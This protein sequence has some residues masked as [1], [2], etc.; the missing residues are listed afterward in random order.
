MYHKDLS[1]EKLPDASSTDHQI[2]LGSAQQSLKGPQNL[3]IEYEILNKALSLFFLYLYPTYMF[4]YRE[5][6]LEDYHENAH[7]GKYW[8]YPLLYAICAL[9]L[10]ASP[11]VKMREKGD[12]LY[13]YAEASILPQA[14]GSPNVT[15][16]QSLLCLAFYELGAGNHSK[17][18]VL[19]GRLKS[20]T[21][22]EFLFETLTI[23]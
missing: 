10:R 17:G 15:V 11:D 6:F 4:I 19:A 9:G 16:V 7:Q 20:S 12:V 23:H 8:S 21:T 14:L 18:W 22:Y 2:A 13:H 1:L 3:H 5:S